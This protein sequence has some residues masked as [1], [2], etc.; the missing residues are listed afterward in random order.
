MAMPVHAEKQFAQDTL[1][2]LKYMGPR[3][4][5]SK[6]GTCTF[7]GDTL[8]VVTWGAGKNYVMIIQHF[9][10]NRGLFKCEQGRNKK[11]CYDV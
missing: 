4:N 5:L 6:K 7:L 3:S 10:F 8:P 1:T 9:T 2:P 11:Y